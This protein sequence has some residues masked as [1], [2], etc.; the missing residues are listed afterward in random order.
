MLIDR[1]QKQK[2]QPENS[3]QG[4][5]KGTRAAYWMTEN[6]LQATTYQS[7]RLNQWRLR[8]L[9]RHM[10]KGKVTVVMTAL[11]SKGNDAHYGKS[12]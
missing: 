5:S 10:S 3:L 7:A 4:N 8:W 9:E 11:I 6:F 1:R 2:Q 12:R